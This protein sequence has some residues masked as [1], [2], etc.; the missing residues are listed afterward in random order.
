[1]RRVLVLVL[2]VVAL[3]AC[4]KQDPEVS[5]NDQLPADQRTEAAA[6]EGGTEG[7]GGGG[8][9]TW[10]AVDIDFESAP[11]TLPA[12]PQTITLVNDG[13]SPHN[14]TIDGKVIVEADGG[15]TEEGEVELEP[16][17]HEFVC[18]VPGHESLM[19]GELTV[20]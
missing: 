2:A 19:K 10:V 3:A 1:M 17:T 9:A 15:S 7:G 8:D 18:S 20:E 5:L 14:V 4:S 11:E 6:T 12:G 13:A 16:G